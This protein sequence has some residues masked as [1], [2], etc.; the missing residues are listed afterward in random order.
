MKFED[1]D[2]TQLV[3][4]TVSDEKVMAPD[5]IWQLQLPDEPSLCAAMPPN[6]TRCWPICCPMPA[7]T[8]IPA[9]PWSQASC[10]PPMAVPW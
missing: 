10:S 5:H 6:F 8:R 9:P 3:I 7:N 4:E 1:V 2:L